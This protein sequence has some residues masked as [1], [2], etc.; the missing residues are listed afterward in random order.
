MTAAPRGISFRHSHTSLL[1]GAGNAGHRLKN[2]RPALSVVSTGRVK[3]R[4]ATLFFPFETLRQ[5]CRPFL[6]KRNSILE[7][8]DIVWIT[9]VV[10]TASPIR[11][12]V[13]IE[14]GFVKQHRRL[15]Y[16]RCVDE[17]PARSIADASSS[18]AAWAGALLV[19]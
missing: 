18:T 11:S 3:Q 6:G 9:H 1:E 2:T 5:Q 8:I 4:L 16:L 10:D 15:L 19:S 14:C 7:A 17:F 12:V 13:Q